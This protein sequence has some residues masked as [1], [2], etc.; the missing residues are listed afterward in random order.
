MVKPVRTP[1][2]FSGTG[3]LF[4]A[5]PFDILGGPPKPWFTR[6]QYLG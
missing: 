2:I 6:H 1:T 4:T 3:I 5:P